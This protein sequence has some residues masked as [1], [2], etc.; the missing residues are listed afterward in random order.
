LREY[1]PVAN[2]WTFK[3]PFPGATR[4]DAVTFV[5]NG[6]AY[7]GTGLDETEIPF[8]D[9][10]AYDPLTDSWSE[11]PGLPGP[12]RYGAVA[13][14]IN[15][16][17]YVGTGQQNSDDY[18][19]DFWEYTPDCETPGGLT[20]TNIKST[21]ARINWD[22]LP[23]AQSYS[24][25]YRQ[26]GTVPW[27]K[28]T[29]QSNFKKL[30]GLSPDTEYDWSVKSVCDAASNISSEWSATQNFTTKPLRLENESEDENSF[31]LYPN[32]LS[33]VSVISFSLARNANVEIELFDL[34]GRRIKTITDESMEAG[35][36]EIA[37]RPEQL[38]AGLYLL[39][40]KIDDE[41]SLV[42][43]IVE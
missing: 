7:V 21:A 9:F 25:R 32:P 39:R 33:S 43:A 26:S 3:A 4:E 38:S 2:Q 14:A 35:D 6:R 11:V 31:E 17:G 13:F 23:G 10:W 41:S 36:H 8:S 12:A 16:K 28:T 24:V 40:I 1:D 19:D 29:A 18:L 22:I 27:T 5:L 42:K 34:A 30:S 20:T 15:G 37:L